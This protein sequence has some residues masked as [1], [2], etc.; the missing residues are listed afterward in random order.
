MSHDNTR[1][2]IAAEAARLIVLRHEPELH[3]AK[4]LA[5]NRVAAGNSRAEDVPTARE[6][7]EEVAQLVERRQRRRRVEDLRTMRHEA[8]GLMRLLS[9]FAPRLTGAAL[10]G[11]ADGRQEIEIQLFANGT[12]AILHR[13]ETTQIPCHVEPARQGRPHDG[14]SALATVWAKRR[15]DVRLTVYDGRLALDSWIGQATGLPIE[16]ATIDELEALLAE[17]VP[18]A[19]EPS[20]AFEPAPEVDRFSAYEALLEPLEQVRQHPR[21]HPEGDALYHSLQVF[22][23]A[24]DELPYDEEFLLAAL[25]HDVGKTIDP[26]DHVEAGLEALDGLVTP[27]TAWLIEHHA[28]AQQLHQGT[29]GVRSR[30]RLEV[31]DD[32]DE[33]VLLARCDRL[34][35]Q[36]GIRVP[37]V[38][39]ALDELRELDQM[40]GG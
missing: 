16:R 9:D 8:L 1:R 35:R 22:C 31:S 24:R 5:V 20:A 13:L 4:A 25:L 17:E 11:T 18:A 28:E 3:R 6:V 34:G 15:F 30:R 36:R 21:Y 2:R 19:P 23:L 26:K 32:F 7:R 38:R 27:R 37:E 14:P 10:A 29:L 40:C 39:D 12:E 33:L